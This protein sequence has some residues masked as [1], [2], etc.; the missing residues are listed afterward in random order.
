MADKDR[1]I[2]LKMKA[3][4]RERER[5]REGV[6]FDGDRGAAV[7]GASLPSDELYHAQA[8]QE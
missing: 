4:K 5:E 7:I 3:N 6:L 2:T 1:T 8:Q